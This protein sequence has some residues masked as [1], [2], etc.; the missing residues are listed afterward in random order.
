[1]ANI[2]PSVLSVCGMA[3]C[4]SLMVE[5]QLFNRDE[6]RKINHETTRKTSMA[7]SADV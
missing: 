4:C 3:V 1:M 7:A 2:I 6:M 5:E